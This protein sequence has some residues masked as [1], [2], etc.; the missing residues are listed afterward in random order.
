M[1]NKV[2]FNYVLGFVIVAV[3]LYA[4]IRIIWRVDI[5]HIMP[6]FISSSAPAVQEAQTIIIT[7]A[8]SSSLNKRMT[9][10]YL[11][12][13]RENIIYLSKRIDVD[14]CEDIRASIVEANESLKTQIIE[15]QEAGGT[16]TATTLQEEQAKLRLRENTMSDIMFTNND[17][18]D[19]IKSIFIEITNNLETLML[20]T[21]IIPEKIPSVDVS[22]IDNISML[23]YEHACLPQESFVTEPK[24]NNY[25][26]PDTKQ[27]E[28]TQFG[29]YAEFDTKDNFRDKPRHVKKMDMTKKENIINK[30]QF[31]MLTVDSQSKTRPFERSIAS[32]QKHLNARTVDVEQTKDNFLEANPNRHKAKKDSLLQSYDYLEN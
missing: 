31:S 17:S 21:K 6:A 18:L 16:V 19:G 28:L 9:E 26:D 2:N 10:H 30:K 5:K 11:N 32:T 29:M 7:G 13:F 1:L 14:K 25:S 12:R 15:A 20:L 4:S 27:P 23:I 8:G 3:I 24:Q 22:Y